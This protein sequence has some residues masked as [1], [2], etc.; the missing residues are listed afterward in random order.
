MFKNKRLKGI[1]SWIDT[2]GQ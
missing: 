1:F 2:L